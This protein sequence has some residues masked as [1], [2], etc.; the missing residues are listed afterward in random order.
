MSY[1][2]KIGKKLCALA[3]TGAMTA[4]LAACG[5][6]DG[7]SNVNG[8]AAGVDLPEYTYVPEYIQIDGSENMSFYNSQLEGDKLYYLSYEWDEQTGSSSQE[9]HEYSFADK[10]ELSSVT[11]CENLPDSTVNKSVD[12][13]NVMDDGSVITVESSY[14]Y[15]DEN[16]PVRKFMICKYD[17][18]NNKVSEV[19]IGEASGK[20]MNEYYMNSFSVD[21][22]NRI[23]LF[24]DGI[25]FLFDSDM[26]YKGSIDTSGSWFY[27]T[28]VGKNGK[29]YASTWDDTT[30]NQVLK[31]ID[32]DTKSLGKTYGNFIN[33][34][35]GGSSLTKGIESDF[36]INDGTRVY[37]YSLETE[38]ATELFTW[39]DSDIFG[40]YVQR[41]SVTDDGRIAV[42]IS[43]WSTGES[44]MAFLTKVKTSELEQKTQITIGALY[45]NQAMLSAAVAFN[46]QSTKYHINVKYYRDTNDYS[47]N[48][49]N[50]ARTAMNKDLI[51]DNCPDLVDI[52]AVNIEQLVTKGVFEDLS[53]WLD[54]SSAINKSDYF[55]NVID[56][57][58]YD[59][60]L[61][62]LP[63][64][65]HVQTVVGKTSDVGEKR[66]WSLD[67]IIALSKE[68]PD[69]AIFYGT[70][71]DTMLYYC[72]AY[73]QD[74]FIDYETGKC[75]FE[76]DDFKKILEFVASFPDEYDWS[77]EDDS[78]P[79]KLSDGRVLLNTVYL[80]GVEDIQIDEAMFDSPV[81]YIGYPTTDGSV[82]CL[83][84][85]DGGYAITSKSNNKEGAWEF[86]EFYLTREENMFSWGFPTN[87]NEMQKLIDDALNVEY[88]TDENGELMLDEEGN[89]IPM[90]GHGGI[91][92]DDWSYTYHDSTQEE[93]DLLLDIISEATPSSNVD[94]Q[95]TNIITEEAAPYFAG[96]K[97]VDDVA[98]VIQS[99]VQIYINE[100]Q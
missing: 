19:D 40:D 80:S 94:D 62:Y 67:D 53:K 82:G 70:T 52:S 63:K 37:E 68:H 73:N 36:L 93:I 74:K 48:A 3:V 22:Q 72:M 90:N 35:G 88:L 6:G 89:P 83:L 71:K 65:F 42:C 1:L 58:T 75:S 57:A 26:S 46:K 56:G 81:T 54:S 15:T 29:V 20:D 85:T 97:T 55:D 14:D 45:D 96:Q 28:G 33:N 76:S 11:L 27:T 100:N 23:Y 18:D 13:F 2:K 77:A 50:D 16:N 59:G 25:I 60:C 79:T 10:K 38:S 43:D 12:S 69:S 51:S 92:Y 31:E 32:F 4:S 34:V 64:S 87:K 9:L 7:S 78:L 91:G 66:G 47:E 95:I 99:R 44:E 84:G 5:G 49:Y 8:E 98:G 39:L 24:A 61:V 21:D 41:M 30:G 17:A 86:I